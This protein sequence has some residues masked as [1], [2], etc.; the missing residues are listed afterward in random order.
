MYFPVSGE[1]KNTPAQGKAVKPG[2]FY[3]FMVQEYDTG[4]ELA[5]YWWK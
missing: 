2:T 4:V 3:H 1:V 5:W